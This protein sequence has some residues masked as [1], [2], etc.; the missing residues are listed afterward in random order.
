L[1]TVATVADGSGSEEAKSDCDDGSDYGE[2]DYD[3]EYDKDWL[4]APRYYP[5][6]P[7]TTSDFLGNSC[8]NG[9]AECIPTA[10]TVLVPSFP[11]AS[12]LMM[13]VRLGVIRQMI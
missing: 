7:N 5:K 8:V 11:T 10:Q 6:T 12:V 13:Y 4:C 1:S 2:A 3:A 9:Y